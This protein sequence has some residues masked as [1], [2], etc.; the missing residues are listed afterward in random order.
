MQLFKFSH[1]NS[2]INGSY[3]V[4]GGTYFSPY[5]FYKRHAATRE[6]P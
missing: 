5:T 1:S 6:T 3:S 4:S 2:N